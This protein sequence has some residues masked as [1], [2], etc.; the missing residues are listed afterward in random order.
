MCVSPLVITIII[1]IIIIIIV[2]INQQG[3]STCV[4]INKNRE[5]N[6]MPDKQK[7]GE[8]YRDRHFTT[9]VCKR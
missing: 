5:L 6:G 8:S 7:G 2:I 9:L 1:I 4:T 3:R